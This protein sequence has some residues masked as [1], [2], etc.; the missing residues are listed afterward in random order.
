MN[1]EKGWGERAEGE[2][3]VRSGDDEWA[4]GSSLGGRQRQHQLCTPGEAEELH[5]V[6]FVKFHDFCFWC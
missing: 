3:G 4:V 6:D 1:I 2:A 5:W